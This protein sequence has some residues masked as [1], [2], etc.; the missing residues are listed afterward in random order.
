VQA[1]TSLDLVSTASPYAME[2]RRYSFSATSENIA[3]ARR[4]GAIAAAEAAAGPV[5]ETSVRISFSIPWH[6]DDGVMNVSGT[7]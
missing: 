1:Q 6:Y 2:C 3:L 7:R 4:V 5:V